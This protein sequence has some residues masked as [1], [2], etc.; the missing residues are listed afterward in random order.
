MAT[1]VVVP[2]L[3]FSNEKGKIVKWL[4]SENDFVKKGEPIFE[5]ETDK[6]VTE[7]EAPATGIL[8]KILIPEG[9]EVPVLTVVAIITEKGEELPALPPPSIP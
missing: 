5:L 6:V 1:E 7:I 9:Q 3:G 4:K 2:M 8:R